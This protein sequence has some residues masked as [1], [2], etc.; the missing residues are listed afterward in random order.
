MNVGGFPQILGA[1]RLSFDTSSKVLRR[2]S[3]APHAGAGLPGWWVCRGVIGHI[4]VFLWSSK[5]S[6]SVDLSFGIQVSRED[7]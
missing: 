4:G 2:C 3:E 6:I 1:P 7:S 5:I